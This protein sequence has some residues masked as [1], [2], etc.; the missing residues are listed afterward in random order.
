MDYLITLCTACWLISG[1]CLNVV[2]VGLVYYIYTKDWKNFLSGIFSQQVD[3]AMKQVSKSS[4]LLSA[5]MPLPKA[6][7]NS[8]AST[9]TVENSS[10]KIQWDNILNLLP[11][12]T[13]TAP[14]QP[15]TPP[16]SADSGESSLISAALETAA[17]R[18]ATQGNLD[19][20]FFDNIVK[21]TVSH[22]TGSSSMVKRRKG[23][24]SMPKPAPSSL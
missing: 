14:A 20:K 2:V 17:A 4:P 19:E 7:S 12:A 13:Q 21:S 11:D 22:L 9:S 18:L 16:K 5:L 8:S 6:A 1:T 10:S 24:D 3:A 23:G 15:P